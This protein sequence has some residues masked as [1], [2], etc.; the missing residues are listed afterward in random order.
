MYDCPG[1]RS[2][3]KTDRRQHQR[4]K[5]DGACI[6]QHEKSVGTIVDLSVGGLSCVCL[7][8]GTCSKDVSTMVS[9]YCKKKDLCAEDINMKVLSTEKIQGQF[10]EDLGMR[11]CRARFNDLKDF[12]KSQL[13]DLIL[14]V[15]AS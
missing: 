13:I 11:K 1:K 12:Q 4:Y 10:V 15:S 2:M 8:Q 3:S 14:H 7:D 6:I 9:I 5:L